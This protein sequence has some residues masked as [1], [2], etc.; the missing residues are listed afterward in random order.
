MIESHLPLSKRKSLTSEHH[1]LK[2][3]RSLYW[4]LQKQPLKKYES[5]LKELLNWLKRERNSPWD[6]VNRHKPTKAEIFKA[7]KTR[8]KV[9]F[10]RLC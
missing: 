3:L 1:Y 10:F 7:K 5:G 9:W 2:M 6:G 8:L 4:L